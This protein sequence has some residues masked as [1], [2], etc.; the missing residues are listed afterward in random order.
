MKG[1]EKCDAELIQQ[2]TQISNKDKEVQEYVFSK[3]LA[4]FV[5]INQDPAILY[6]ETL[7]ATSLYIIGEHADL[8]QEASQVLNALVQIV[9]GPVQSP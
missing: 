2:S 7:V 4:L 3:I 1:T 9:D 8:L 6:N 5:E